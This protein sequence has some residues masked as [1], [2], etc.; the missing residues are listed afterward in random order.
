MQ[1]RELIHTAEVAVREVRGDAE[2]GD[3][4]VDSRRAQRGSCFVAVR[5]SQAD[6][7]GF[8]PAA[9]A[10]GASAVVCDDPSHVPAS[11]AC[12]VVDDTR[13]AAGRLAQAVRGWPARQ[14]TAVGITGT[15]GKTT[16]AY[17]VR[18][19]LESLGHRT[20]LLGTITYETHRRSHPAPNTTPDAVQLAALTEEM[21]SAGCSHLVMEVSSHALDQ[22]RTGGIEFAAGVFTNLTGDHL[23]YH[24]TM[25]AYAAAKHKLFVPMG[26][27]QAAV[28]N[29]D[30]PYFPGFAAAARNARVLGYGLGEGCDL[31]AEIGATDASGTRFTLHYGGRSVPV[32]TPLIGKHNVYNLLAGAG[33]GL[34]LGLELDAVVRGIEGIARVPGRLE[35]VPTSRPW[36]VFV[37]YAHT[38]DAL[39]NVLAAVR[40]LTR[41]RLI[42]VF[43]CGGDR[44]RT[45]RPRM[46]RVCER[47]ADVVV[48]TSDNPRTEDPA[49]ILSEILT[50]FAPDT[51][52]RVRVEP[53]RRAAIDLA[54]DT[55]REG[56]VV[57]IAG[58]GHEDYQI[59]GTTKI[60]FDDRRVAAAALRRR[61]AAP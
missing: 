31:R 5:G 51:N 2:I 10:A 25:D 42:V 24:G 57:L 11:V 1:F 28:L 35:R 30:D 50:G 55:A 14:L 33:V 58:K 18:G 7:H 29:R 52:G 53:D 48:V 49:A 21:V 59:L 6:G 13:I 8:I 34:G 38:D 61:E 46:A 22:H 4:C 26:P 9:L 16:T 19:M 39:E 47:L 17:L 43:G 60:D 45:K 54:I 12:A 3:V 20:G 56:D 36:S 44:D 41:G 32:N 37:D 15:N 23:D 40:P 27:Q